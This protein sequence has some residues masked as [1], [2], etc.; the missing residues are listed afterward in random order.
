MNTL[1]GKGIWVI[2]KMDVEEE[3]VEKEFA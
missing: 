1:Q 2:G 3:F